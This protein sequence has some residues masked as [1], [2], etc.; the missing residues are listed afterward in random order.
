MTIGLFGGKRNNLVRIQPKQ[1]Y[2]DYLVFGNGST[3][4]VKMAIFCG[5]IW[6]PKVQDTAMIVDFCKAEKLS[7]TK[8]NLQ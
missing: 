4:L 5:L 2:A 1:E 7:I 8:T 6:L 3:F